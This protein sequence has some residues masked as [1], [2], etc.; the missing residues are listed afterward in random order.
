[1]LNTIIL[2]IALLVYSVLY[3]QFL[4]YFVTMSAVQ[5]SLDVTPYIL[6]RNQIDSHIRG[7]LTFFYYACL[8]SCLVLTGVNIAQVSSMAFITSAIALA[9]IV[10]DLVLTVKGNMPINNTIQTWS[11][12]KY[13]PDWKEYRSRWFL[14]FHLRQLTGLIGFSSLIIQA[15]FK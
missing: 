14:F 2:L 5:K 4:F 12:G 9:A 6:M 10:A 11:P 1:M 3:S 15:V 8:I 7:K 13:P